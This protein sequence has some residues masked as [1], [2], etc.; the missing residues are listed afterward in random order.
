MTDI[1]H[2]L[3]SRGRTDSQDIQAAR[4]T[5]SKAFTFKP[6]DFRRSRLTAGGLAIAPEGCHWLGKSWHLLSVGRIPRST[7]PPRRPLSQC[8]APH[9]GTSHR[10][11]SQGGASHRE[12]SHPVAG[13]CLIGPL[14]SGPQ[15]ALPA[16]AARDAGSRSAWHS[17]CSGRSFV[18]LSGTRFPA[19]LPAR[20]VPGP[21]RES[22]GLPA[23]STGS[24]VAGMTRLPHRPARRGGMSYLSS[25]GTGQAMQDRNNFQFND[26]ISN[27]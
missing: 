27:R 21:L 15:R 1:A 23:I 16:C 4:D 5:G 18:F 12:A 17:Q 3:P 7:R 26:I 6:A 9:R 13:R 8:G 11:T 20:R 24:W 10:G 25:A 14:R 2:D 19:G 22:K